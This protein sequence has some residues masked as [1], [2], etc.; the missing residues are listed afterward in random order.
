MRN[1]PIP[2]NTVVGRRFTSEY[3]KKVIQDALENIVN[4][5]MKDIY[6]YFAE[7]EYITKDQMQ[8]KQRIWDEINIDKHYWLA[9]YQGEN[10]SE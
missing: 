1:E 3:R 8:M 7:Q 6:P 9:K 2:I 5:C 10:K 4:E